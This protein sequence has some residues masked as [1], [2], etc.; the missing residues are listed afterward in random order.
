MNNEELEKLAKS[1][2]K[3]IFKFKT[4][5]GYGHLASCLSCVDILAS[6]YYDEETNYDHTKDAIFLAMDTA[7][8]PFTPFS[9]I[10]GMLMNQN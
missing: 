10:W 5:S 9:L 1:V 3:R 6:L 2:R 7:L 8:H 4:K